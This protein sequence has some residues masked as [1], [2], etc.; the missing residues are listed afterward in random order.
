MTRT[1]ASVITAL[2]LL[3]AAPPSAHGAIY[4]AGRTLVASTQ[5][6]RLRTSS[7]S[8]SSSSS[9][10][11]HDDA[12]GTALPLPVIT[13]PPPTR[14]RST[15]ASAE[16]LVEISSTC[17][18]VLIAPT[19]VLTTATCATQAFETS[20]QAVHVWQHADSH[21]PLVPVPI[22]H[23]KDAALHERFM[24]GDAKF[25]FAVIQLARA[26]PGRPVLLF[27]SAW[28]GQ[29]GDGRTWQSPLQ[30]HGTRDVR[31]GESKQVAFNAS[32]A[33]DARPRQ[34]QQTRPSPFVRVTVNESCATV[35]PLSTEAGKGAGPTFLVAHTRGN[36]LAGLVG[37]ASG[38]A[39]GCQDVSGKRAS[40]N[41]FVRVSKLQK[42]IDA[43]SS[44][45][46][47]FPA[48]SNNKHK[49][50]SGSSADGAFSGS[51]ANATDDRPSNS[52][53]S[54]SGSRRDASD[55]ADDDIQVPDDPVQPSPPVRPKTI[56]PI[57]VMSVE[58]T[59]IARFGPPIVLIAPTFAL[60][61]GHWINETRVF[62]G[63]NGTNAT[64]F[65]LFE[66]EHIPVKQLIYE[67]EL[68]LDGYE[69]KG[70]DL[71][72]LEL[73]STA[74]VAPMLL[75]GS[76]PVLNVAFTRMTLEI[77]D[78][79]VGPDDA[80]DVV[81]TLRHL[82][83]SYCDANRMLLP[84]AI[85]ANVPRIRPFSPTRRLLA[86]NQGIVLIDGHLA[87]FSG[88]NESAASSELYDQ[89]EVF[90]LAESGHVKFLLDAT[91]STCKWPGA[92]NSSAEGDAS[93][94]ASADDDDD[95]GDSQPYIVSFLTPE[96]G[97]VPDCQGILVAP[98]FVLTTASCAQENSI[99]AISFSAL[100][101]FG[102]LAPYSPNA[103]IIH[104]RYN[105]T[106]PPSGRFDVA[107]LPLAFATD[108]TPAKLS[109]SGANQN[110]SLLAFAKPMNSNSLIR[111]SGP[112]GPV[113]LH[114]TANCSA[115]HQHGNA[116]HP[117]F[118]TSLCLKPVPSSGDVVK[119]EGGKLPLKQVAYI[120]DDLE[121]DPPNPS[122]LDKSVI[123]RT[124]DGNG[125]SSR[126]GYSVVGFA[127]ADSAGDGS[128]VYSV[129]TLADAA[130][131]IN[132]YVTGSSWEAGGKPVNGPAQIAKRFIV[133]LRVAQA[134]QNFCGGSLIAPTYVLTAAHCVMDGLANWVSIGAKLS[135]GTAPEAIQVVKRS[136]V[137]H[138]NYGNPSKFSFDAAIFEISSAAY[139]E[140][141]ILDQSPD[142]T[143]GEMA[144]M[145]G[146]GVT[147]TTLSTLATSGGKTVSSGEKELSTEIRAVDLSLMSQEQC[148]QTLPEIDR[149]MLCAVG[150]NGADA[151]QGDS[152]GPL[153]L[154][155][156]GGGGGKDVLVGFVSA[157]YECGLKNVPGIYMRV[158]SLTSFIKDNT[159]G[160]QWSSSIASSPPPPPPS[161]AS[162]PS[163]PSP[164]IA[165]P[166][167]RDL[168]SLT[169]RESVPSTAKSGDGRSTTT[170]TGVNVPTSKAPI[171]FTDLPSS[172]NSQVRDA[173]LLFLLGVSDM[174]N[175]SLELLERLTSK[176]N[177][178]RFFSTE[179]L[180]A[181]FATIK[182][183]SDKP[184]YARMD[185]FGRRKNAQAL[186]SADAMISNVCS[187]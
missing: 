20:I 149:S 35:H 105:K 3:A 124:L 81:E 154:P 120:G 77:F 184:L 115:T 49:S 165:N 126:R 75:F 19:A 78:S 172:V 129:S 56:G 66:D 25:D 151:C 173:L 4:Q 67:S 143:S 52:T 86:L 64:I 148:T 179:D 95:P 131:F 72:V 28:D 63:G 5:T 145:Y 44:G 152:G 175:I 98:K 144:T 14:A 127:F 185:R 41:R 31:S 141:V 42:F 111:A 137:I 70:G 176:S 54:S 21:T 169:P 153:V 130:V 90:D 48:V 6:P 65:A 187:V 156:Q 89:F 80:M 134:S 68:G 160:A 182:R 102:I 37:F 103:T 87:G 112:R 117:L 57:G 168:D 96:N 83:L 23:N 146:Y 47:W 46:H 166:E 97:D 109:L 73:E 39:R 91:R 121:R 50:S 157:G 74:S 132:A 55:N 93:I 123:G 69:G 36:Q 15:S 92:N 128:E 135:S 82:P 24:R 12:V 113:R 27:S 133:G 45:H 18:G 61:R 7:G 142:F 100:G 125:G 43:S 116:T 114:Q 33:T 17:A 10:S 170:P 122:P 84:G 13:T 101:F 147:T 107:I 2:L 162:S 177:T 150:K 174:R 161:P 163:N 62:E 8:S 9:S 183:H 119:P 76:E 104:P 38:H 60:T 140:P 29:I 178:V 118:Q 51:S 71:V 167:L 16:W 186:Q 180:S 11:D 138:K 158:S 34:Q 85:C 181:L 30:V 94:T 58:G 159:A 40:L 53:S 22:A 26:A 59:A 99:A 32:D 79:L 155:D 136:V 1:V 110:D 88:T 164:T 171:R 106:A 139:A 108:V